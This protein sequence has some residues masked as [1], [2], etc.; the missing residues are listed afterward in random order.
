MK[1]IEMELGKTEGTK[2]REGRG[3]HVVSLNLQKCLMR[4]FDKGNS[5]KFGVEVF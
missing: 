4:T 5:Q 1:P 3:S 2:R